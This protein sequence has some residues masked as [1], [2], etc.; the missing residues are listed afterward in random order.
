LAQTTMAIVEWTQH[1]RGIRAV[2][3]VLHTPQ[4]GGAYAV[5][6]AQHSVPS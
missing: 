4:L 2:S 5:T 6:G 1:Y 3:A